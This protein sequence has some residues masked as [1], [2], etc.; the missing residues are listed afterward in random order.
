VKVLVTRYLSL[1]EDIYVDHMKFAAFMAVWFITLLL[2]P[3]V[4]FII[5]YRFCVLLFNS[6]NYVFLLLC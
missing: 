5:V 1:L 4:L 2:I 3:L 6:V